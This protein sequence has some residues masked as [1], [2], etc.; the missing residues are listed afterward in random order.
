M[1]LGQVVSEH[2]ADDFLADHPRHLVP[3][4]LLRHVDEAQLLLG[5]CVNFGFLA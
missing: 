3:G 5:F 4:D 2:L 1:E